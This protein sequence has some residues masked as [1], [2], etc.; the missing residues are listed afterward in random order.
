[1]IINLQKY[2]LRG[3]LLIALLLGACASPGVRQPQ[4]EPITLKGSTAKVTL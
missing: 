1:M 4:P 3:C 2:A